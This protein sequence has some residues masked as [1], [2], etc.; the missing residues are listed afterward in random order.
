[1]ILA[2]VTRDI[3]ESLQKG[4][5]LLASS[6]QEQNLDERLIP[7]KVL[8]LLER[9]GQILSTRLREVHDAGWGDER[10][11][12][13]YAEGH[14]GVDDTLE[15]CDWTAQWRVIYKF[16]MLQFCPMK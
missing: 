7:A 16:K 9:V 14:A 3:T 4:F 5:I 1:M 6:L 10:H 11:D 15:S 13:E 8:S 12:R 2:E